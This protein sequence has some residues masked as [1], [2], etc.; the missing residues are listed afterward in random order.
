MLK[1]IHSSS[2]AEVNTYDLSQ[3]NW[4]FCGAEVSQL[5]FAGILPRIFSFD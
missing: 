4:C 5:V 2:Y 3:S 1:D